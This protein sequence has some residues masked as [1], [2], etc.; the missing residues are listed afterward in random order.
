VFPVRY[1]LYICIKGPNFARYGRISLSPYVEYHDF[2]ARVHLYP[3]SI[4]D[5]IRSS[6]LNARALP[7]AAPT[8]SRRN[9]T[10]AHKAITGFLLRCCVRCVTASG[11]L[12]SPR[13]HI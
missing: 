6:L 10:E 3:S 8:I 1:E 9:N 5:R 13:V 7:N 11:F 2:I 12:R 4:T